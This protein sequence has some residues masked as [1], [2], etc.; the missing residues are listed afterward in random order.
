MKKN[1]KKIAVIGRPNV[2]KSSLFNRIVKKRIAIVNPEP[3]VTRDRLS[4]VV[5]YDDTVF[6]LI[7]TGGI[8]SDARSKVESDILKQAD[9]A[10]SAADVLILVVDVMAGCVPL[11]LEV[12][13]HARRSGKP[14]IVAVNK[15]DNE[16]LMQDMVVFYKMGIDPIIGVSSI[17]GHGIG[18]LV[19]RTLSCLPLLDV[20]DYDDNSIKV[21]VVGRPNSGKSSYI[22]KLL[23][24]DR[25]IV[26]NVPGTTRDAVDILFHKGK[27][28]F[29]FIDTAGIRQK[30]KIKDAVEHY[31]VMRAEISMSRCDIAFVLIDAERG[32]G[33]LEVKIAGLV[34]SKGK[35]CVIGVNKWD[36]VKEVTQ[37]DYKKRLYNKLPFL[38]YAPVI[39]ISALT[40]R[41]IDETVSLFK[42]MDN[43]RKIKVS[44]SDINRVVQ[45]A[46]E[47]HNPPLV[48][49]VRAKIYYTTQCGTC[50][51][52][53]LLFVNNKRHL[54]KSYERYLYNCIR[55]SF[56][57]IGVPIILKFRNRESIYK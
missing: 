25:V 24:E 52:T 57:I 16:E 48:K 33:A 17:H 1:I 6:E 31:S 10:I 41:N 26:D 45:S 39:F 35:A 37:E 36:L 43:F 47:R 14:I 34:A 8:H 32:L 53:F 38:S 13:E 20:E 50:P 56:G 15:C 5:K 55:E 21:A 19:E 44:T 11:D 28:A 40:G 42:A 3:G 2:G 29:T 12:A 30:K 7:D 23:S 49:K 27:D 46:V 9:V 54:R 4:S 51:P 18:E 22:N